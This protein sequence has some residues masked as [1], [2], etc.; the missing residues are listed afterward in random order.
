ML[1]LFRI[2]FI[3][4][5]IPEEQPEISWYHYIV[6]LFF[7][8]NIRKYLNIAIFFTNQSKKLGSIVKI[9]TVTKNLLD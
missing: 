2:L 4:N 6:D 9:G 3:L 7:I 8:L 1:F 5:V